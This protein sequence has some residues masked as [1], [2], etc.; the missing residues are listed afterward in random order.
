MATFRHE[1]PGSILGSRRLIVTDALPA[2]AGATTFTM[3]QPKNSCVHALYVR[4]IDAIELGTSSNIAIKAGDAAGEAD[5]FAS[6]N[7]QTSNFTTLSANKVY[8]K[9]AATAVSDAGGEMVTDE[10]DIHFTLTTTQD[11]ANDPDA[12]GRFEFTVVYRIF[13]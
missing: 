5:V 2:T 12:N 6:G 13:D 7:F 3:S 4:N 1:V 9:A 11:L 8:Y 10:R